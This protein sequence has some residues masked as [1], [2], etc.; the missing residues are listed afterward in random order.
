M[1]TRTIIAGLVLVLGLSA[2]S[3]DTSELKNRVNDLEEWQATAQQEI[4]ALNKLTEALNGRNYVS[5]VEQTADGY[6]LNFGDGSTV[7]INSQSDGSV[8]RGAPDLDEEKGMVAFYLSDDTEM[9][10]PYFDSFEAVRDRIQS[11]VFMPDYA[12]GKIGLSDDEQMTTI[13]SYTVRPAAVATYMVNHPDKLDF[14]VLDDLKTRG[15]ST[16]AAI[17]IDRVRSD[18]RGDNGIVMLTVVG[19]GFCAGAGYA[20]ALCFSNGAS[21]YMTTYTPIWV[22]MANPAVSIVAEDGTQPESTVGAGSGLQLLAEMEPGDEVKSWT[23]DDKNV[24]LIDA[25]GWLTLLAEG[26]VTVTVVTVQGATA[27]FKLNVSSGA[28]NV[29]DDG[30]DQDKAEIRTR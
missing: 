4:S 11:L 6:I 14:V 7:V 26:T 10:V 13:L 15:I 8:F 9:T 2:C 18:V 24:A 3:D 28:V 29:N 1:K 5:S 16:T 20:A 19:S 21:D 25:E 17:T 12:D 23:T 22:Q 30:V 27:T